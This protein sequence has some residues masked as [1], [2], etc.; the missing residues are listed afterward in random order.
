M[1]KFNSWAQGV[2]LLLTLGVWYYLVIQA[3]VG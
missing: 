3:L 1:Y 2:G